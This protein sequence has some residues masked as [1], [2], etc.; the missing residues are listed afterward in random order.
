MQAPDTPPLD[1]ARAG[2]LLAAFI[3]RHAGLV[4]LTGA[5]V[6]TA[7][8]I[9]DYR[10]LNGQWKRPQPV[11]YQAFMGSEHTRQRYWARSLVGW[12]TFGQ[13]RAGAAHRVLAEL[14]QQGW[15]DLLITQ[16]VD[17]LHEAA[18]STALVDLHGR[19]D[20]VRCMSCEWRF[21]RAQWQE[22]LVAGNPGWAQRTALSAPDG[23][24]DLEAVDFSDFVI[25]PCPHCGGRLLKP[26][27]VFYGESVPRERVQ[28]S[29]EAVRNARGVLVLGSSLMVYSGYRFVLAAQDAG[30]PV[31]A[32]N[33][34]ATRGD[35]AFLF[36][37]E[38][39]VGPTLQAAASILQG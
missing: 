20:T 6:S 28:R 25:P 10:D 7:S 37:L 4:V 17:G 27:V 19:L 39:D 35:A 9:P 36:K 18:G 22:A 23:D 5:G 11:T 12:R 8:G 13:A 31:V 21:S 29:L 24:A 15:V 30:V 33:R 32:V 2:A 16:N 3:E 38:A 1:P 26:D 34:G 14:E